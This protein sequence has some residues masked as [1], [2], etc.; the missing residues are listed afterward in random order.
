MLASVDLLVIYL[1]TLIFFKSV[2]YIFLL[3]PY[4]KKITADSSN[5]RTYVKYGLPTAIAT[6]VLWSSG[7]LDKV[8]L[9]RYMS[10][11][12]LGNYAFGASLATYITYV[13]SLIAPLLLPRLSLLY[14]KRKSLD[15]SGVVEYFNQNVTCVI[16]GVG[17]IWLF[18]AL[19]SRELV[20]LTAGEKYPTASHTLFFLALY[21]GIDQ[22]FGLWAYIYHLKKRPY[23]LTALRLIYF[24]VFVAGL[25]V[26]LRFF[27]AKY[28]VMGILLMGLVYN[29]ILYGLAQRMLSVKM[30]MKN[31]FLFLIILAL[32]ITSY[33][34]SAQLLLHIKAIVLLILFSISLFSVF[35]EY[36]AVDRFFAQLI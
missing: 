13:G 27:D 9:T 16:L 30:S 20:L 29:A 23:I 6:I 2:G 26:S 18:L 24:F 35:R 22:I 34:F 1:I 4:C 10:F 28:L 8:M 36:R 31:C 5:L 11:Y 12:D 25:V 17:S 19:F 7:N 14:D 32:S 33:S 3:A 21:Y 15:I